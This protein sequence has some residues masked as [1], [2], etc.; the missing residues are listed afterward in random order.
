[1]EHSEN[2]NCT[3]KEGMHRGRK[4]EEA[5]NDVRTASKKLRY[6]PD[7]NITRGQITGKKVGWTVCQTDIHTDMHVHRE[8]VSGQTKLPMMNTLR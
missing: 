7:G 6:R 3:G 8:K 5:C 4:E 2:I 1:M